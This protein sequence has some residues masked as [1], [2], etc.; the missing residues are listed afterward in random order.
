MIFSI[1]IPAYNEEQSIGSIIER[2]LQARSRIIQSTP[3]KEVEIVVINDG[4]KDKTKEIV[5]GFKEVRLISY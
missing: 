3:V 4:S 1:I 2:T 5:Q